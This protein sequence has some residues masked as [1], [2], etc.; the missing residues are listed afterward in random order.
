MISIQPPSR[1]CVGECRTFLV[2]V[3]FFAF[4]V[5]VAP[6]TDCMYLSLALILV[7]GPID[8]VAITAVFFLMAIDTAQPKQINMLLMIKSH[9]G[10]GLVWR[11]ISFFRWYRNDRVRYTHNIGRILAGTLKRV[12][13]GGIMAN[14]TFGIVTPFAVAAEALP[15]V[16]AFETGL[17]Q[18]GRIRFASV[19]LAAWRYM[20]RRAIVMAGFASLIHIRHLGMNLVI[21]MHRPVLV[22]QF[23]QQ[24]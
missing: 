2:A 14:D 12:A 9:H 15:M 11:I 24:H 22:N 23:I 19:A 20:A 21:E 16:R 13:L 1:G 6:G 5:F 3:A 4:I 7:A 18:V 17:A 10:P 8:I